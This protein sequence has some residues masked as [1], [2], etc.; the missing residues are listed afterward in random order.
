MEDLLQKTETEIR[1]N[2]PY[3]EALTVY[4]YARYCGIK[5]TIDE[6]TLHK[7]MKYLE[8]SLKHDCVTNNFIQDKNK[9]WHD[10][11]SV[12]QGVEH[13]LKQDLEKENLLIHGKLNV[14]P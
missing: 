3:G 9:Y 4:S 8:A 14:L 6:V 5:G 1:R 7:G 10:I 12:S 13:S 11:E 2:K